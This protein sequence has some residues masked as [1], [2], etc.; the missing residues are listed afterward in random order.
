METLQQVKAAAEYH[1]VHLLEN[2]RIRAARVTLERWTIWDAVVLQCYSPCL[3]TYGD[4]HSIEAVGKAV[5]EQI[6]GC[7]VANMGFA[8]NRDWMQ[9]AWQVTGVHD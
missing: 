3:L 4:W 1:R 8:T 6:V 9:V 7:H 2:P 5:V